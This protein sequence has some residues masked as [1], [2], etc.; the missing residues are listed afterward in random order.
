MPDTL[1]FHFTT[2][3]QPIRRAW[4]RAVSEA[5]QDH[6]LTHS[7]ASSIVILH[8][9]PEG[10]SQTQLGEE[11]GINP[12]A[13]VRLLDQLEKEALIERRINNENRRAKSIHLLDKG[14]TLAVSMEATIAQLREHFLADIPREDIALTTQV[15]RQ[16]ET[17]IGEYLQ[18][19]SKSSKPET[20]STP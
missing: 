9:T 1:L 4:F 5:L 12:G 2:S 10:M 15:L 6:T 7:Q 3:L 18:S 16:F 17:R 11:L 19:R 20:E 8:R 14:Q 13:L